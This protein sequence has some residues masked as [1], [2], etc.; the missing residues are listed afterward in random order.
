MQNKIIKKLYNSKIELI[1][2][3]NKSYF[4]KNKSI[5]SDQEYDDIKNEILV[6][7]AKYDFL[8]SKYSPSK[9]VGFKPSKNFKKANH[10]VPMLSLSNAFSEEDLLNFEKKILN[11]L[12]QDKN[13]SIYYSAEPKIDGISASLTYK[14]G[15]FVKGLSR[16]D[17]RAGEDITLNLFTI[18]DIPKIIL[19]KDFPEEIDIRGEVFIQNSDFKKCCFFTQNTRQDDELRRDREAFARPSSSGA[20]R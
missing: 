12:S 5:V 15:K 18:N 7:E 3:Y 14:Q 6:L 8:E 16:G 19:S 13:T 4:N 9:S 1:K 20:R 10:R 17:G 2:K 11:F